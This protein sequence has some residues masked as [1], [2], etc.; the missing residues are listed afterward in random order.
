MTHQSAIA[1][2]LASALGLAMISTAVSAAEINFVSSTAM[3][4]PLEELI[5][6]FEKASG[7][8]V[9]VAFYPAAT[10]VI[11]VK[12]GVPADL[13]M[14]TP[15][16]IE[17]LTKDGKLVAGSRVDFAHSSVGVAVRAGAPK[18]DI[19]TPDG[20]KN[21]LLA[22]K[23]VG[24]SK[25]PSGVYLMKLMDQLGIADQIKAKTVSPDLGVR[26]GTLVAKGEAEIGVQQVNEL[27]PIA[28]I[29]FV[30][31]L[32]KEL[33][34]VIVYGAARGTNAKEWSAAEALVKYLT[35]PA[36][37]AILKKLGLDPA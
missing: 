37:A 17:T 4:E 21:A 32:P 10:L 22:A 36:A 28:G 1:S 19:S 20:L 5:P 23:S 35:S 12:E 29:D 25:G 3:R 34:T 27:L 6:A 24:V 15:D 7:H 13:V 8:K 2:A 16:N 26:V 9:A 11:K 30:G 18:P 31:K 33:R 14:T